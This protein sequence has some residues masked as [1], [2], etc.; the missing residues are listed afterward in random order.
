MMSKGECF[1][2]CHR[3]I[4]LTHHVNNVDEEHALGHRVRCVMSGLMD[5]PVYEERTHQIW[6][7]DRSSERRRDVVCEAVPRERVAG[8]PLMR[9]GGRMERQGWS[10]KKSDH[11]SRTSYL[12][13]RR[14]TPE[15]RFRPRVVA[16]LAQGMVPHDPG[17]GDGREV[18]ASVD[19][20]IDRLAL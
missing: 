11:I 5:S 8:G 6:V 2:C 3:T 19:D 14:G 4:A 7:D 13:S 12:F 17:L 18:G 15:E 9:A 16:L 1:D 10:G 20:L